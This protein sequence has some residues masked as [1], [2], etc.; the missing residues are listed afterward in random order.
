[1]SDVD[2]NRLNS[3]MR[4]NIIGI[5]IMNVTEGCLKLI[6]ACYVIIPT[7]AAVKNQNQKK[8]RIQ[9]FRWWV[10][11]IWSRFEIHVRRDDTKHYD[12][13]ADECRY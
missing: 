1:M 4:K 2:W 13:K 10:Q 11:V 6:K 9:P 12:E 8:F 3:A 7:D 5:A